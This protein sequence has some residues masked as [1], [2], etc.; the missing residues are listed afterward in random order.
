MAPRYF[1]R[2]RAV[3]HVVMENPASQPLLP[4][5]RS[6]NHF[7]NTPIWL[8]QEQWL[9]LPDMHW[10]TLEFCWWNMQTFRPFNKR[11]CVVKWSSSWCSSQSTPQQWLLLQISTSGNRLFKIETSFTAKP[12]AHF[13][14]TKSFLLFSLQIAKSSEKKVPAVS[15]KDHD[16]M[17]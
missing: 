2:A 11:R 4:T 8:M 10:R 3:E 17:Y 7:K 1:Y 6:W 15:C 16:D 5:G 14:C 13:N 9:F 12:V